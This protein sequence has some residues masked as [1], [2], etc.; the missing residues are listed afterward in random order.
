[1]PS[2]Q[3]EICF[4]VMCAQLK[5]SGF[6]AIAFQND[7]FILSQNLTHLPKQDHLKKPGIEHI[8]YP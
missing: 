3:S 7:L 1:M 8:L 6:S 4:K 5:A 2:K